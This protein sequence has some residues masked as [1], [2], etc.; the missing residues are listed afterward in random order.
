MYLSRQTITASAP[1]KVILLGE[2]SVLYGHCALAV[3]LPDVALSVELCAPG[4]APLPDSWEEA[5]DVRGESDAPM[6]LEGSLGT[7]LARCLQLVPH[8]LRWEKP[9]SHF[10][11]QTIR[12]RSKIPFGAGMG[13]SAALSVALLRLFSSLQP[14]HFGS[15][16]EQAEAA[17]GLDSVFHGGASGVDVSTIVHGGVLQFQ[18]GSEFRT[19][20]VGAP[21][22]LVVVDSG[23]RSRTIEMVEKVR[24]LWANHPTETE[25]HLVRLGDLAR[26]ASGHL[27]DGNLVSLGDLLGEAHGELRLLGL[28]SPELECVVED[29]RR[30]GA[31]GAKLTG[32]GGGGMALGLFACR[33]DEEA[34]RQLSRWNLFVTRID[35]F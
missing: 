9:L 26:R 16:A 19:I 27:A 3:A 12:V 13:A 34:L 23:T 10:S 8:L 7:M 5:W 18:K 33:P 32:A 15:F 31:L 4:D 17:N 14:S 25:G 28:S 20:G 21:F 2:H 22:W 1:G 24:L 11:P 29:L 30:V 35:S 6:A